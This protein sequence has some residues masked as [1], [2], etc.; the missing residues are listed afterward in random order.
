MKSLLILPRIKVESANA[1]SGLLYGFPA[2]THFLGFVHAL[3]RDL[4]KHPNIGV[5]LGG[6][7]IICHNFQ[8]HVHKNGS[9]R[10]CRF[11]LTRN[12]LT[13]KGKNPSF[14]EEGRL[15]MEVSLVIECDFTIDDVDFGT[16]DD[17]VDRQKFC[18]LIYSLVCRKRLAGGY[19]TAMSP[20]K[21]LEIHEDNETCQRFYSEVIKG[22]MPGF[23]L[24]DRADILKTY[25]SDNIQGTPLD[26]ILDVYT[27]KWKASL[28]DEEK[29]DGASKVVWELQPKS[30]KGWIVP[31]QSGYKAISPLYAEGKVSCARD[32]NVPFCFV[33]PIYGLAEWIG[34]HRIRNINDLKS[35]VWRYR[36]ENET[37]VCISEINN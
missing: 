17:K 30:V 2:V 22:L 3:S 25:T 35:I 19:I 21:F 15:R 6:C 11:S 14:N 28:E 5:K 26:V 33:E 16:D 9:A 37:Y 34:F 10:D 36:F 31:I 27:F 20:V 12:P 23:V 24:K 13:R 7:G 32:R 18:E 4:E 1:I 8:I 29:K